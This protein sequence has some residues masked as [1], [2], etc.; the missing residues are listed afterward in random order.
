MYQISN[1]FIFII[2]AA[3]DN[4]LW[5]HDE[6][7][8][9]LVNKDDEAQVLDVDSSNIKLVVQN[10]TGTIMKDQDT[11]FGLDDND[12]TKNPKV[13]EED[14]NVGDAGQTWTVTQV[15]TTDAIN[16]FYTFSIN[17]YFLTG[18]TQNKIKVQGT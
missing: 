15:E 18:I 16:T 1:R 10:G 11:V 8:H 17:N 5:R 3:P 14:L 6:S 12:V 9:Q 4:Q 13:V 2:L 7:T